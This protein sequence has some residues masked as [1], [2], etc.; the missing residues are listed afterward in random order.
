ME[1][2]T[3]CSSSTEQGEIP[4]IHIKRFKEAP[5][6]F[7]R[8]K[9]QLQYM[10]LPNK[11][12]F[13]GPNTIPRS[14]D[15]QVNVLT[16]KLK[17]RLKHDLSHPFL[18]LSMNSDRSFFEGRFTFVSTVQIPESVE[19]MCFVKGK[20]RIVHV[21]EKTDV[22]TDVR[23]EI[24]FDHIKDKQNDSY[25]DVCQDFLLG[26][27]LEG[28]GDK[29]INIIIRDST[30]NNILSKEAYIHFYVK[31]KDEK[32]YIVFDEVYTREVKYYDYLSKYG[33][34]VVRSLKSSETRMYSSS[35]AVVVVY[36]STLFYDSSGLHRLFSGIDVE[37]S[38]DMVVNIEDVR[39]VKSSGSLGDELKV[40][41]G[42]K[43]EEGEYVL[44]DK[45]IYVLEPSGEKFKFNGVVFTDF[46]DS[47]EPISD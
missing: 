8:N 35:E 7:P 15:Y 10:Y 32:L 45:K 34:E 42:I 3:L 19:E 46:M 38:I 30:I 40:L 23:K 28:I 33:E 29:K 14:S 12:L 20:E 11:S 9:S 44:N 36:S 27:L 2:Y 43:F 26:K 37:K 24:K 1:E 21:K 47:Q 25:K 41:F 39:A 22:N 17:K 6:L 18:C 5:P 31:K 4:V 13:I 16:T